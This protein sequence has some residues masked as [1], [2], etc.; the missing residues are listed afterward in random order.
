MIIRSIII[1]LIIILILLYGCS[2]STEPD[3][4]LSDITGYVYDVNGIPVTDVAILPEYYLELSDSLIKKMNSYNSIFDS[5]DPGPGPYETTLYGN[6]PNPF[7]SA[8]I[9]R[10]QIV[11]PSQC[12]L[13]I[14]EYKIKTDTVRIFN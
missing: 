14:S 8:T 12:C 1:F 13:Y 2:K 4:N 5:V 7:Y 10:Y 3:N 6:Y 9:I 11:S